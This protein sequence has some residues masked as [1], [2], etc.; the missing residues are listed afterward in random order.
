M[1]E[2]KIGAREIAH[3]QRTLGGD[4]IVMMFPQRVA[5][6]PAVV[7]ALQPLRRSRLSI[8]MEGRMQ[9]AIRARLLPHRLARGQCHRTG[10]GKTPHPTQS[11][12]IVI[13]G[14]VLLHQD[15]DMLD[16]HDGAAA[17]RGGQRQR[18][19]DDR[20]PGHQTRHPCLHKCPAI[21][22]VR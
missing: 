16:I 21:A 6:F 14:T 10:I 15:D 17:P 20:G 19:P 11:P 12:E 5:A 13:E 9:V 8:Q 4:P 3:G 7:Q 22:H 2:R 18:A 1:I